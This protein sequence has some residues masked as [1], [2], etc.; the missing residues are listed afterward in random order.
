MVVDCNNFQ[1]WNPLISA[2]KPRVINV[3]KAA[4]IPPIL[5]IKM[6]FKPIFNAQ[7]MSVL[8]RLIFG[9]ENILNGVVIKVKA[10]ILSQSAT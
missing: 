8:I 4:P 5:G 9:K 1:F 7:A 10:M 6:I 2:I 3:E